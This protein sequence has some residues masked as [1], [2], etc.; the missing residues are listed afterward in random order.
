MY[1]ARL[2]WQNIFGTV[3]IDVL[4]QN[5]VKLY[6]R[7]EFGLAEL[8]WIHWKLKK[9]VCYIFKPS[10]VQYRQQKLLN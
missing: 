2:V 8:N 4:N 6:K 3:L 10:L 7:H 9:L 5:T 1:E